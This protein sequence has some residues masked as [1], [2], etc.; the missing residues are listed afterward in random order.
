MH[1]N[2]V[3]PPKKHQKNPLL[4]LT[5]FCCKKIKNPTFLLYLTDAVRVTAVYEDF[6]HTPILHFWT[7]TRTFLLERLADVGCFSYLSSDSLATV[8]SAE[9]LRDAPLGGL[10]C[11][12]A[13]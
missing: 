12:L 3:W 7:L 5:F 10:R 2:I 4:S 8:R 11:T 1:V 6:N 13:K 9:N